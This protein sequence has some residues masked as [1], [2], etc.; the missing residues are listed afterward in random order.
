M[1]IVVG[2]GLLGVGYVVV[3][4]VGFVVCDGCGGVVV[5]GGGGFR[6]RLTGAAVHLGSKGFGPTAHWR[7]FGAN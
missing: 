5:V 4:F 1:V 6:K 3:L 2:G 7:P